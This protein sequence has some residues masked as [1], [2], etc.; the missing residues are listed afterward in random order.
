VQFPQGGNLKNW[1]VMVIKDG[2]H[3]DFGGPD[4]INPIIDL[5]YKMCR[6][7]GI[8]GYR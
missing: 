4:D 1:A 6:E 5:F 7:S 3:T 8:T 2:E